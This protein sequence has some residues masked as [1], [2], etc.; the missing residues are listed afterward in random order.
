[1]RTID[2]SIKKQKWN[3]TGGEKRGFTITLK[4]RYKK[5]RFVFI[6]PTLQSHRFFLLLNAEFYFIDPIRIVVEVALG[7][8]KKLTALSS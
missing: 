5:T 6:P 4:I 3:K 7:S 8:N 1:M 2:I